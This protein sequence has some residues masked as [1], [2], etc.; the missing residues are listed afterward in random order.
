MLNPG[1]LERNL[2]ASE[3]CLAPP[4]YDRSSLLKEGE[5]EDG[6]WTI[7]YFPIYSLVFAMKPTQIVFFRRY[8]TTRKHTGSSHTLEFHQSYYQGFTPSRGYMR[9]SCTPRWPPI[10]RWLKPKKPKFQT[11]DRSNLGQNDLS[12]PSLTRYKMR[13][14]RSFLKTLLQS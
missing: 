2:S 14:I 9:P 8:N 6:T 11:M 4:W 1:I 10:Y 12:Y 3:L 13:L 7:I 5:Q